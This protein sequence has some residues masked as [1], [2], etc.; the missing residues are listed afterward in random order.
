MKIT[1]LGPSIASI[2]NYMTDICVIVNKIIS[3]VSAGN[4]IQYRQR[5][6]F[7]QTKKPRAFAALTAYF[8]TEFWVL[9]LQ[10]GVNDAD[11]RY[12]G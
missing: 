2:V 5:V 9:H 4:V 7:K 6:D 11:F 3:T 10:A 12:V 8:S 1:H